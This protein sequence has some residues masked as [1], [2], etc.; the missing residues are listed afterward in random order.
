MSGRSRGFGF[1]TFE[2]AEC[3]A[4]ALDKMEGKS[5]DGRPIRVARAQKKARNN[6]NR[7]DWRRDRRNIEAIDRDEF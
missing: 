3:A 1:V 7:G 2:K 4:E 6:A 5:I